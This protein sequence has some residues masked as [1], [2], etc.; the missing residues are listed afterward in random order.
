MRSLWRSRNL[1]SGPGA[2]ETPCN[3][4]ALRD[5]FTLVGEFLK[6]VICSAS[7]LVSSL[8]RSRR[9]TYKRPDAPEASTLLTASSPSAPPRAKSSSL[10]VPTRE[11]VAQVGA[12]P[13][14]QPTYISPLTAPPPSEATGF[15]LV[16]N[17]Q[18]ELT[19]AGAYSGAVTGAWDA[20][21]RRAAGIVLARTNAFLPLDKPDAALFALIRAEAERCARVNPCDNS[22]PGPKP[23]TRL[24]P[25]LGGNASRMSLGAPVLDE[26]H[27]P[28]SATRKRSLPAYADG[29]EHRLFIHPLGQL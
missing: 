20:A 25:G 28:R 1:S 17:L 3:S 10:P 26:V 4:H 8:S 5:R 21:T 24:Y 2:C 7:P 12:P 22:M 14:E 11:D 13:P 15:E 6:C 29:S 27:R 16:R 23:M 9:L 18:L 19:R